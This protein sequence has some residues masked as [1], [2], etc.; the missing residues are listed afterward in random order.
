MDPETELWGYLA[1][2]TPLCP[3]HMAA[4]NLPISKGPKK[5]ANEDSGIMN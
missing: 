5:S 2:K 1:R 4:M 3:T